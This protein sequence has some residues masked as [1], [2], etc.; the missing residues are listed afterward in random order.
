MLMVVIALLLLINSLGIIGLVSFWVTQRTKQIG[1][2]RALGATKLD[3]LKYFLTENLIITCIGIVIGS[4]LA[5]ALNNWLVVEFSL[6]RL[7]LT[8]LGS[9][10]II[11][12]I[13]GLIAVCAPAM[14]AVSVP[15]AVATRS[16]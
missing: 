15:P 10:A 11:V 14:R 13:M 6:S 8:Y 5:M 3:I 4:I 16:V 1:T 12:I 9:G 7:P 2:R